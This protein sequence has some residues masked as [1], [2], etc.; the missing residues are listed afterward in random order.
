[1]PAKGGTGQLAPAF[2][3]R[4]NGAD[5]PAQAAA[6]LTVIAVQ[7][8]VNAPSMFTLQLINWDMARLRVTWSDED[9]FAEG[10]QV[11]VHMGYV[12]D[13]ETLMVGEIT[14]L[15]PQFYADEVPQLTVRGYD[16]R[17]RLLRG[18]KTRSFARVKDSDIARRIAGDLGLTAR[19][20]D[21]QVTLEYVLQHNQTDMEF[22]QGR[23]ERI[24]Y[25]VV[26]E[27]KTLYFRPR[28]HTASQAITLTRE[29][30]L[31][32]FSL[33]SSTLSQADQVMV[34]GWDPKDKRAILG[35]ARA[36]DEAT[37]MGGA[38]TGPQA[39]SS[40]FGQASLIGVDQPVFSLAEADQ[41]ALGRLNE[42]ALAYVGGEGL[43]QG[44]T[45]LRAGTVVKVEGL[46]Q[47][48]SGLYY[49]TA[50]KHTYTP[51]RGYRTAFSVRRNAT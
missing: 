24:G 22:L 32:E 50:T 49:V 9:L 5:L 6:D 48:F 29:A 34:R 11:E 15:E 3:V 16:R 17:H 37:H 42:M 14:G 20:E 25:E 18:R 45:D 47:R 31:I 1:M 12:D 33:R 19:V 27:D 36:G 8:D 51:A 21:S 44:R 43:C 46:G 4:V 2:R 13:L 28:Q 35:R 26:V 30:D 38:A 41:I 10:S 7:E 39:A 23:A 40:A